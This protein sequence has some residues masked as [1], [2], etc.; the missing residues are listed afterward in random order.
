MPLG[1]LGL[2]QLFIGVC[3]CCLR[4]KKVVV[5]VVEHSFCKLLHDGLCLQ[6][7]MP[8]HDVAMPSTQHANEI[9]VHFATEWSHGAAGPQGMGTDISR[10][11]AS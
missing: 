2:L 11:D 9:C 4:R 10:R 3:R 6:V 1:I 5:A 7:E 8:R